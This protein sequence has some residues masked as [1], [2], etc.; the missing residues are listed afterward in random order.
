MERVAL[1]IEDFL[2]DCLVEFT[3]HEGDELWERKEVGWIVGFDTVRDICQIRKTGGAILYNVSRSKVK[4][5]IE[6]S[7][8]TL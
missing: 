3:L 1:H 5:V 6:D 8:S 2:K 4:K 7:P